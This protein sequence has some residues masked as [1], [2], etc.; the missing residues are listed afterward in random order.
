[1][2]ISRPLIQIDTPQWAAQI[3][4]LF[5]KMDHAYLAASN[6]SGLTCTH[7]EDNC[8]LSLFY[9]HT[10]LELFYLQEGLKKLDTESLARV[11]FR[12]QEAAPLLHKRAAGEIEEKIPCPLM[13]D[14]KCTLYVHRPMICRLHGVAH[15]LERPGGTVVDGPGC[16]RYEERAQDC[17]PLN[18]TPLY[19]EMAYLER[20]LREETG[21][22][23]R[24]KLTIAEMILL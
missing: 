14:G 21:F 7:C 11:T 3:G 2:N 9:H 22:T 18:R 12:A 10:L 19:R 16:A 5:D 6:A 24:L 13:D 4:S 23:D 8:C 17:P 20:A 15:I 1:M